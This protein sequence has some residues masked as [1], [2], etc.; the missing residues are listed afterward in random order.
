MDTSP[1]PSPWDADCAPLR[2]RGHRAHREPGVGSR[3]AVNIYNHFWT[4]KAPLKYLPNG[5]AI[6]NTA[7]INGQRGNKGLIDYST[8]APEPVLT[9]LVPVTR[10]LDK[11]SSF[12]QQVPMGF[13]AQPDEI[14]PS[15]V[16][17]VASSCRASTRVTAVALGASAGLTKTESS[18]I[19]D[20]YAGLNGLLDHRQVDLSGIEWRRGPPL[21]VV[22]LGHS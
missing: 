7:S 11:T 8:V 1:D 9:P 17:F 5:G 4:T 21:R 2:G 16:F 19:K 20:A 22:I 18:A 12:G 10:P 14:T 13:A 3:A 6:I 15:Y